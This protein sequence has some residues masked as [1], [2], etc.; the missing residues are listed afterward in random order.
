M[1]ILDILRDPAWQFV[2]GLLSFLI[3]VFALYLQLKGSA[4]RDQEPDLNSS[5]ALRKGTSQSTSYPSADQRIPEI[6][7]GNLQTSTSRR[8]RAPRPSV[9]AQIMNFIE[10]LLAC[11][12]LGYFVRFL[13]SPPTPVD[14][15]ELAVALVIVIISGLLVVSTYSI[16][17]SKKKGVDT[18]LPDQYCTICLHCA[19]LYDI[20][21]KGYI[22]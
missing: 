5:L 22:I 8:T 11:A 18:L 1:P 7:S 16:M 4:N 17:L 21:I 6:R 20:C 12:L 19:H 9:F 3:A 13:Y 10:F 2:F 14:S 15:F